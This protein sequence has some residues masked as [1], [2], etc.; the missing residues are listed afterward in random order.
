[1]V[2]D[3]VDCGL[4]A[5]DDVEDSVWKPGLLPELG[6]EA[7]N[8]RVALTRLEDEGI[9]AGNRHRVHPHRDHDR[10]VEGGDSG[11]HAQWL[12]EGKDVDAGRDLV[13]EVALEQG[14]QTTGELD[15]LE[16]AL[17]LAGGIVNR[18]SV[19]VGDDLSQ[20]ARVGGNE[21]PELEQDLRCAY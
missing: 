19:L 13:R 12:A 11:H 16:S 8:A 17:N 3:G 9:A 20:L 14:R 15:H 5:V 7:R 1:M 6:H 2:E 4:V 10:K 18:L 21:A